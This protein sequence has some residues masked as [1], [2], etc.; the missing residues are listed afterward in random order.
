VGTRMLHAHCP[1]WV[2]RVAAGG[3]G[4]ILVIAAVGPVAAAQPTIERTINIKF[5]GT[6]HFDADPACGPFSIGVTEIATG[7]DHLVIV[8]QGDSLHVTFGETFKILMVPDDP[9]LPTQTRQG[10]DALVFNLL[11]NGTVVFHES[12][13]DYGPSAWMP[14]AKIRV[15]VTFV[16]V[17]GEVLVDHALIHDPPP[18]GC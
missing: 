11:K 17:N 5:T 10:T 14:F 3:L 9:S 1:R 8:D 15:S 7:N 18:P 16:Y 13:H 4:L 2:R 6:Q 12:F